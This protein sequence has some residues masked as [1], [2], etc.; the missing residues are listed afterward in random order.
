[1]NNKWRSLFFLTPAVCVTVFA[2]FGLLCNQPIFPVLSGNAPAGNLEKV[3]DAKE[4]KQSGSRK[5]RQ[6]R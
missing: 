6:R 4:K 2:V 1:M 5:R 3:A